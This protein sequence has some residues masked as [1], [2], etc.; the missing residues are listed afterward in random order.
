MKKQVITIDHLSTIIM[1]IK[2]DNNISNSIKSGI[3][4]ILEIS[5]GNVNQVFKIIF[6]N[7]FSCI[8][9]YAPPFAYRYQDIAIDNKRNAFEVEVL[10]RFS[11]KNKENYPEIY[12]FCESQHIML[13][14]DLSMCFDMREAL[15]QGEIFNNFSHNMVHIFSLY[16]KNIKRNQKAGN[17]DFLYSHGIPELQNITKDFVFCCPF[18]LKFQEG[19]TCLEKNMP[20]IKE[21]I[22][23]NIE[24]LNIKSELEILYNNKLETLLHGDLHT[25]SIMINQKSIYLID[26]EFSKL[27]PISFDIGMLLG[28]LIISYL[29]ANYHLRSKFYKKENFQNWLFDCIQSLLKNTIEKLSNNEFN[30]RILLSEIAGYCGIEIIRRTIG[31]AKVKDFTSIIDNQI[32]HDIELNALKYAVWLIEN[33]N[34][35]NIIE[36]FMI[37]LNNFG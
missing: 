18:S 32:R 8:A 23:N 19:I 5:S 26:P 15:I 36:E 21:N 13:M 35:E 11:K 24:V 16:P 29:S 37:K 6:N 20:W 2:T 3:K 28:N 1:S 27:G 14:Q 10:K 30:K 12:Y 34:K 17:T 33:F 9:K 7:D 22:F 31:A 25:G 4:E